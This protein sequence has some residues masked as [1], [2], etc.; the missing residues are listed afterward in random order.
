MCFVC[1][2][3][4]WDPAITQISLGTEHDYKYFPSVVRSSTT[5][6]CLL[7]KV[8][9]V[10]SSLKWLY[11]ARKHVAAED[12]L[13]SLQDLYSQFTTSS[14]Q[15]RITMRFQWGSYDSRKSQIMSY[16]RTCHLRSCSFYKM[17]C[18]YCPCLAFLPWS[19][20]RLDFT[21]RFHNPRLEV[22][23]KNLHK[24]LHLVFFFFFFS[25]PQN[26]TQNHTALFQS[27]I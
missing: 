15:E 17:G 10:I 18:C 22:S 7:F 16:S 4:R 21:I 3:S 9:A 12:H 11:C 27:N 25:K 1:K 2:G 14:E 8:S 5:V 6:K 19:T 13:R 24:E 20:P 26:H 23:I